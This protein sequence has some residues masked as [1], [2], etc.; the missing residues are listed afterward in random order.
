MSARAV[1]TGIEP[2]S[3]ARQTSPAIMIRRCRIRSPHAPTGKPMTSAVLKLVQEPIFEAD[4]YPSSYG[5]GPGRRAQDAVAEIHHFTSKPS[6]NDWVVEGDIKACFDNDDDHVLMDLM[7][8]V[9]E[10]G[11]RP[12]PCVW[13][14]GRYCCRTGQPAGRLSGRESQRERGPRTFRCCSAPR[15]GTWCCRPW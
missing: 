10:G 6:Y 8:L 12:P 14:S 1:V 9:A 3:S 5:Y 4:F 11:R 13:V 7:D 2:S 15:P